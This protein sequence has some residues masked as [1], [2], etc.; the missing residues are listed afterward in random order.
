MDKKPKTVA[1]R[2][3]EYESRLLEK[4]GRRLNCIRLQP[5]AAEALALFEKRGESATKLI[6]RLLIAAKEQLDE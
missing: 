6:N 3:E 4:G 1:R 5:E 2:V